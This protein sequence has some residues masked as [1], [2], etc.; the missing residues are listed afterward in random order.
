MA[1]KGRHLKSEAYAYRIIEL[2]SIHNVDNQD[3]HVG[4]SF[5]VMATEDHK[6]QHDI[7]DVLNITLGNVTP[8]EAS[9]VIERQPNGGKSVCSPDTLV[10][11]G[12][13]A[14]RCDE[15]LRVRNLTKDDLME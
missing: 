8:L 9:F 10:L 5:E 12:L 4:D 3:G 1:K 13:M 14:Q 6:R 15:K 2:A 7:E 11:P